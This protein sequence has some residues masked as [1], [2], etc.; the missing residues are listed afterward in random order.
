MLIAT[1]DV[2]KWQ[3]IAKKER[4]QSSL[5]ENIANAQIKVKNKNEL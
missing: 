1:R 5:S 4:P 3:K 2:A